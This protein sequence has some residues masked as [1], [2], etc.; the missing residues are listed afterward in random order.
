MFYS[1]YITF[2]YTVEARSRFDPCLIVEL[3]SVHAHFLQGCVHTYLCILFCHLHDMTA[4]YNDLFISM[5]V[6]LSVSIHTIY[7]LYRLYI[8]ICV[9]MYMYVDL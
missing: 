8:H 6:H 4:R 2:C 7:T 3:L 5:C 9:C 1:L